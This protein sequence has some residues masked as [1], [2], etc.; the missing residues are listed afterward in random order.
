MSDS[1]DE[2]IVMK[3]CGTNGCLCMVD[4]EFDVEHGEYYCITCRQLFDRVDKDGFGIMLTHEEVEIADMIFAAF[5]RKG[6]GKWTYSQYM[7]FMS[8]VNRVGAEIDSGKDLEDFFL[9]EYDIRISNEV[10]TPEN[11]R[12]MYG[13]DKFNG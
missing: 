4:L 13:G 10:L 6:T 9:E 5:D 11:L 8:A 2:V 7:E 1:D 3:H 12:E